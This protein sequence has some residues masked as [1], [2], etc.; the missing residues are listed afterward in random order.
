MCNSQC[1]LNSKTY[2]FQEQKV[3]QFPLLTVLT[4]KI[5]RVLRYSVA[6]WSDIIYDIL[7]F[8]CMLRDNFSLHNL[9][10]FMFLL[11]VPW[12]FNST[13]SAIF[14]IHAM[15]S[16]TFWSY[17]ICY[18]WR[19]GCVFRDNLILHNRRYLRCLLYSPWH[20][21]PT[22]SAIFEVWAVYSV[23]F[24]TNIVCDICGLCCVFRDILILHNI[25]YLWFSQRTW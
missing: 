14:E 6:I 8:C 23:T 3:K 15:C 1:Y 19:L 10:Y 9:G 20:F 13:Q 12:Y 22:Q 24:W 7:C 18:T 17:T 11:C 2:L 21:D 25:R 16:V 5:N 4:D